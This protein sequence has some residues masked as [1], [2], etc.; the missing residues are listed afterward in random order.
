MKSSFVPSNRPP[1]PSSRP[2]SAKTYFEPIKNFSPTESISSSQPRS[3]LGLRH[4]SDPKNESRFRPDPIID[5]RYNT[6]VCLGE[7]KLPG[8]HDRYPQF[9]SFDAIK[10]L[11]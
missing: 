6:A 2:T 8:A 1:R 5:A 4:R 10:N 11:C 9:N 3:E 7:L